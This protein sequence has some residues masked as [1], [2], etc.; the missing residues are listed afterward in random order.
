MAA[1]ERPT[2]RWDDIIGL[3]RVKQALHE[4]VVLPALRA[5]LFQGIRAP[6]RGILLFGPP[7]TG[8]T[9]VAKAAAAS[10]QCEFFEASAASL[11]SKWHGEGEKQARPAA[12]RHAH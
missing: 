1:S 7:G 11:T 2:T 9:L 4:A 8:K 3:A 10:A 12:C 5:D 6:V